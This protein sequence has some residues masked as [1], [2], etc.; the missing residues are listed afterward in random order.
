MPKVTE[1]S[2]F[3]HSPLFFRHSR[4]KERERERE[5][6]V[7][8]KAGTAAVVDE[9][10]EEPVQLG[11]A[12]EAIPEATKVGTIRSHSWIFPMCKCT[13]KNFASC[14]NVARPSAGI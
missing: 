7:M 12:G 5:V 13:Q 9:Q 3:N 10:E 14:E 1:E 4:E 2:S 8:D 11:Y 6:V